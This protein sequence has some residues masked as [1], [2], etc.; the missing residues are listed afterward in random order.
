METQRGEVPLQRQHRKA[1]AE[2]GSAPEHHE[3]LSVTTSCLSFLPPHSAGMAP[4]E[5]SIK[6]H[7]DPRGWRGER[8]ERKPIYFS[9]CYFISLQWVQLKT[10]RINENNCWASIQAVNKEPWAL[11][12]PKTKR[13]WHKRNSIFLHRNHLLN[14][15]VLKRTPF[16]LP[17]HFTHTFKTN[18]SVKVQLKSCVVLDVF[19]QAQSCHPCDINLR[20]CH[21][22]QSLE[23]QSKGPPPIKVF[24]WIWDQV[25]RQVAIFIFAWTEDFLFLVSQ[26]CVQKHPSILM[27]QKVPI[28]G[29]GDGWVWSEAFPS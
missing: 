10:S 14:S 11:L 2:L 18:H 17:V 20:S 8:G 6:E 29:W 12:S 5:I 21:K 13:C 16:F 7:S 27:G 22:W 15:L 4:R 26:W 3:P 24:F 28:P 23:T 1:V 9:F 25:P 19:W